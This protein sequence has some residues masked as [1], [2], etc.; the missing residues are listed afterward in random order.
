MEEIIILTIPFKR[1]HNP[2]TKTGVMH[3]KFEDCVAKLK[4]GDKEI[5][6]VTGCLG[7]TMEIGLSGDLSSRYYA[8]AKEF[9]NAY[10]EAIGRQDLIY[11]PEE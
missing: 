5:G 8:T 6:D 2:E 1:M 3:F 11:K 9:W 10:A 7:A 4:E